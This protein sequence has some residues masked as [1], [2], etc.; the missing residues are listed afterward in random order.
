MVA[1]AAL[2]ESAVAEI[3]NDPLWYKDAIIYQM[4][5]KAFFDANDDGIGDFAGVT[6]K[7]DYIQELGVN[8]IWLLPFYPSPQRDDG[9]DISDYV[10]VSRDYGTLDDFRRL[11][12]EAHR[13]GLR[14]ITELVINHT[15]DQHPWFQAARA[16]EPGSPARDFYVWSDTDKKF[17]RTRIIFTDTESSNWAWDPQAK[18]YYW[19][20]FFSHQP[21]LN[22]N[23]PAVVDAVIDVMRF[24]LDL[25]VD[26]MRLDAIPYLCVREGTSNENLPETHA[27]LRRM[28]AVVDRHYKGR[29][30]L[31]EANQWPEDVREYFGDGDECHM[32]YHFP[33]MP[34]IF[35][36]LALEDRYPIA[37]IL[38][39][40]PEIPD[41]CQ[42]AIF[43]R[44][45]DELTLEMVTDRERDYMYRM[46]AREPRMRVNVGIR[47]RLATL[48][49]NDVDRIKLV[50]SLLMSMPGSPIIYYGDEI[51]M[52][53]NIYIGD[54]N[55]VRTPMQWSIDRNA[56]F[57]RADPQR[58][59][60][61]LIMDPIYGYQAVNV[62]AQS[63]DPSSLLNW[64]RRV[65]AVRRQHKCLGRGTLEFVR[66][67]N[68]KIFAYLRSYEDQTVLCVANLAQTAQAV[69]L[70][71]SQYRGRIPVELM[72]RNSFPPIGE[73]P[74]FLTLAPHGF[75]WLLLSQDAPPPEWHVEHLPASEL[76]VLVLT[77]GLST[78]ATDPGTPASPKLVQ[79]AL[80]QYTR[81]ILPEFLANR[82][83]FAQKSSRIVQ[84]DVGSQAIWNVADRGRW[85]LSTATVR[86]SDGE[87]H[88]YF[89]PLAIA[90]EDVDTDIQLSADWSV[91]KVREHSRAGALVDAFADPRFCCSLAESLRAGE[92]LELGGAVLDFQPPRALEELYPKG[93]TPVQHFSGEQSNTVVILGET[94]FLKAY[95]R[96]RTGIALEVEMSGYLSEAGF[97]H[98]P[99]LVGVVTLDRGSGPMALISLF[100]FV[101]NQGDGW[102]YTLDHLDRFASIAQDPEHRVSAHELY[103]NQIQTLGR[104]I[105]E[106]HAALARPTDNPAFSPEPVDA[107]DLSTWTRELEDEALVTLSL[108]AERA[109]SLPESLQ[110]RVAEVAARRAVILDLLRSL[111]DCK[112]QNVTRTRFHGDLHL[113][114]V[115]LRED[116]FVITDFEG[117]PAR[118][119]E[120]RRRKHLVARDVAGMLRSFDYARAVALER[121]RAGRPDLEGVLDEALGKWYELATEAFIAGHE[122]G[123]GSAASW[124]RDP[125][126]RGRLLRILQ[127]EKA[128]YELRYELE[129]RPN[130]VYVPL[131]GL[132]ALVS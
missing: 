72:N 112:L 33:L 38:R 34:R 82:R 11:V 98:S 127:I 118:S 48:L 65:L 68:R 51:G 66:P 28:R 40:T 8:T 56:G 60:L 21:D 106:L 54:R 5:V 67:R 18:A 73:L 95:R 25:G 49:S 53:D 101:R 85:L 20:R 92:R 45:H 6:Q 81:E 71:L 19:H 89:L 111:S 63:R 13:R 125:A 114:Q 75:F 102:T 130:W 90:W 91:A 36:A 46:Y 109:A 37:E 12:H 128:L 14:V 110:P 35:M 105:G 87:M 132:L 126:T 124:P 32:A 22:H 24:W 50:N 122:R 23:N 88:E 104:R 84:V 58:L 129:T 103:L 83:W 4:H 62:E 121:V 113:G 94:F 74:Y 78:L 59:Y 99:A 29:M 42:W 55:G 61:P 119:L 76:P 15:S 64:T 120:Q 39:Q 100:E 30:F 26:G 1:N 117:E 123:I 41:N 80:A 16:A 107:D 44:N 7:L 27:V 96:L 9:Y 43:L 31:A 52:G 10:D 47:R 17:G 86:S 70:D 77:G 3:D 115:L 116:D 131:H 108:L 93:I 69:E 97:R 79:R 2:Q 57:S